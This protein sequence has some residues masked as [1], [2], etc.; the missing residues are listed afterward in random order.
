M[1]HPL[2]LHR[3]ACQD[4]TSFNTTPYIILH[5]CVC[6]CVC[7]CVCVF[8]ERGWHL[9]SLI[10]TCAHGK[11]DHFALSILNTGATE[12]NGRFFHLLVFWY[13]LLALENKY[14]LENKFECM[15]VIV[16]TE[17]PYIVSRKLVLALVHHVWLA[18][19]SHLG[20]LKIV[21]SVV[22]STCTHITQIQI[23]FRFTT[24]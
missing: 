10:R 19:H 21:V 4:N 24:A 8:Q 1:H 3:V 6:M 14:A 13:Y 15:K 17:Q 23:H 9:R 16:K 7:V 20:D 22:S 2:K 12:K 18:C 5:V 11:H